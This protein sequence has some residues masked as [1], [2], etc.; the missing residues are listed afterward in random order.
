[1]RVYC[2]SSVLVK[3]YIQEVETETVVAFFDK[4]N[5]PVL[6]NALQ[7]FEIRNSIRQKVVRGDI[8][9]S[10]AVVGLRLLD[11]DWIAGKVSRKRVAWNSVFAKAEELSCRLPLK[12]SCRAIDPP[13]VAIVD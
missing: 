11:D 9:E 5:Q 7:E 3:L 6:V 4:R 2:D 10:R 8:S 12:K 1:M 13:P